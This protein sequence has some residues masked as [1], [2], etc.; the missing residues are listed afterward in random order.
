MAHK[1]ALAS[2]FIEADAIEAT[3]FPE[4]ARRYRVYGV[5][6][7]VINERHSFEGALPERH[8]VAEIRK[9]LIGLVSG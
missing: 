4:L 9:A 5:P 2:P 3:E 1:L 6:K 8:Y 7:V